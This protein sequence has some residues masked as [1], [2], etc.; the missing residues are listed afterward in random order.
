M[1]QITAAERKKL[2]AE[3]HHLKPLVQ[4]GQK[5]LTDSIINAV[6]DALES[7]ELIKLKFMEHKEDKKQLSYRIAADTESE[8]VG[9]IGNILILY[10]KKPAKSEPENG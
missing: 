10:R 9:I 6:D 1:S 5:G 3:A 2:K 4:I 7:H 8:V